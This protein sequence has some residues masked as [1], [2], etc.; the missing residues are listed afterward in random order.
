MAWVG[1]NRLGRVHSHCAV[2][3]TYL[4]LLVAPLPCVMSSA[5]ER[6][7]SNVVGLSPLY[8]TCGLCPFHGWE[9]SLWCCITEWVARSR[10]RCSLLSQV[11]SL[12]EHC[13]VRYHEVWPGPL[14]FKKCANGNSMSNYVVAGSEG[15][16]LPF[17]DACGSVLCLP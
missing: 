8:S 3:I 10:S 4:R 14:L 2:L 12:R 15:R 17:L 11:A 1:E 6:C 16:M 9:F 7:C 5:A 13:Y